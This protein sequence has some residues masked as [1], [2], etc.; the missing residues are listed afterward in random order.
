MEGVSLQAVMKIRSAL[1]WTG[2]GS[3]AV[4]G[5]G[6]F[7]LSKIQPLGPCL[8]SG[9]QLVAL[10]GVIAGFCVGSASL[11]AWAIWTVVDVV[12]RSGRAEER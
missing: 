12:R 11:V 10:L 1:L 6:T 4:F 7:Y 8:S 5:L 3:F 2:A 9:F